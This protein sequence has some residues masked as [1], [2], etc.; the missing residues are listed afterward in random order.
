MRLVLVFILETNNQTNNECLPK[1]V[2]TDNAPSSMKT[3][4]MYDCVS[5][6]LYL[7]AVSTPN[8][9]NNNNF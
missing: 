3:A 6:N 1:F 8:I 2:Q 7:R 5:C 9:N 4:I